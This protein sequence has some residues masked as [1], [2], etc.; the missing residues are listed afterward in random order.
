MF[1]QC[2]FSVTLNNYIC[3]MNSVVVCHHC[4]KRYVSKRNSAKFCSSKCRVGYNRDMKG[5]RFVFIT[6]NKDD[7]V[8][9]LDW[10]PDRKRCIVR[11]FTSTDTKFIVDIDYYVEKTKDVTFKQRHSDKHAPHMVNRVEI[12]RNKIKKLEPLLRKSSERSSNVT[13]HINR[14]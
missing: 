2:Y 7:E 13:Q 3:N 8:A 5:D 9:M 14:A 10:F 11:K 12:W 1:Q 4:A 6:Q